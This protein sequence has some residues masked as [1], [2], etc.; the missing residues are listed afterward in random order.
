[1]NRL[2]CPNGIAVQV[3]R[4]HALFFFISRLVSDFEIRVSDLPVWF[5]V[6]QI[7]HIKSRIA[8]MA[9]ELPSLHMDT[10]WKKQPQEEKRRLAEAQEKQQAEAKAK[11]AAT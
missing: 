3:E 6:L 7:P 11:A 2:F 1:M 4:V 8:G 10:D 9:D 5:C